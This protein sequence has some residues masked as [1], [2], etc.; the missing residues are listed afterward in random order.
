ME[1]PVCFETAEVPIYMCQEMHLICANCRP[2][3]KECPECRAPYQAQLKRH[4]SVVNA[5][6]S[7]GP[8]VGF[9][10]DLHSKLIHLIILQIRWE[11]GWGATEAERGV[12]WTGNSRDIDNFSQTCDSSVINIE[13]FPFFCISLH[14]W[15]LSDYIFLLKNLKIFI[16][17]LFL[18]K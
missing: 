13:N 1:W 18:Q 11:D 8:N 15:H 5:Q 9:S 7:L 2:K 4:R 12:S 14:L 17:F 3:L 6:L 10:M 16:I